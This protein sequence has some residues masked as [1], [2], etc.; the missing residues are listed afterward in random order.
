MY[1][2]QHLTLRQIGAL[3]GMTATGVMKALRRAGVTAEQGEHVS[4]TCSQ[5]GCVF[6]KTRSTWKNHIDHYCTQQC[7]AASLFNP[8]YNQNRGGQLR[9][10][11][12][13]AKLFD[14]MPAHVV[15]H[16]DCDN[17]HNDP[18]NLAAFACGGDH[19]SYHRGGP[20][21]MIWDGRKL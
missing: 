20:N 21:R 6:D 7:Y 17:T 2:R 5:C 10:R 4:V 15:H 14:L 16:H 13:V 12:V 19:V 9:A 8:D 11:A 3:I 18:S 1:V